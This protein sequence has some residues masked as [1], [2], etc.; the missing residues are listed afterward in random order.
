[1]P[2]LFWPWKRAGTHLFVIM[3]AHADVGASRLEDAVR[4]L[5]HPAHDVGAVGAAKD[6]VH[7]ALVNHHVEAPV[8]ELEVLHVHDVVRHADA[9]QVRLPHLVDH[10]RRQVNVGDVGGDA[11]VIHV[12]R[13]VRIA[14]A[15]HEHLGGGW[16]E[17]GEP[18]RREVLPFE[19]PVEG[20]VVRRVCSARFRTE[21][22]KV[23]HLTGNSQQH[24]FTH[25]GCPNSAVWS[26]EAVA[27]EQ[28]THVTVCS[29]QVRASA[30][31]P[32]HVPHSLVGVAVLLVT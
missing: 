7:G 32:R 4:L 30:H 2:Q 27:S 1:M 25:I 12:G 28:S 6:A 29:L 5:Q 18:G 23:N 24:V 17:L 8:G 20:L 31:A 9:A 13:E 16:D 15:K 10:H 26:Y 21:N 3:Q 22:G 19:E 11:A 14:A